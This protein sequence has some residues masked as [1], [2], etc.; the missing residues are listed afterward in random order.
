MA[1]PG[2]GAN[3]LSDIGRAG[4]VGLSGIERQSRQAQLDRRPKMIDVNGKIGWQVGDKVIT[5]A[6]DSPAGLRRAS[7]EGI[8]RRRI[9]SREGIAERRNEALKDYYGRPRVGEEGRES[10]F[11]EGEL[12]RWMAMYQ[13]EGKSLEN[14]EA[15]ARNK[16]YGTPLPEKPAEPAAQPAKPGIISR[17]ITAVTGSGESA[18]KPADNTEKRLDQAR[19]QLKQYPNARARIEQKLKELGIDPSRL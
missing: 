10:R 19:A 17:A 6:M 13:K 7:Q 2:R 1:Q 3:V 4:M 5:T 16:V 15:L 14:A 11:R 9:A 18:A 12:R 8:E